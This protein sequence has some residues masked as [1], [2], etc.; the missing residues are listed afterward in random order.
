ML[1]TGGAPALSIPPLDPLVR[2]ATMYEY[3]RG[4]LTVTMAARNTQIYGLSRAK[5]HALRS[6]IRPDGMS[7]E[8]DMFFPRL[9]MTSA[10]KADSSYE[11]LRFQSNGVMNIT[12]SRFPR[13]VSDLQKQ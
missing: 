13:T 10:Y 12:F 7:V 4:P 8:V 5:I 6:D 9:F 3:R 1:S 2:N 11:A